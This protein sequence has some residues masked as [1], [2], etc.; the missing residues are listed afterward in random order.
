MKDGMNTGI[1]LAAAQKHADGADRIDSY[2]LLACNEIKICYHP[3]N[4]EESDKSPE[5]SGRKDTGTGALAQ[6]FHI[7]G[8]LTA[9]IQHSVL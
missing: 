5:M 2:L 7:A 6:F 3:L 4:G 1:F 9:N 8:G